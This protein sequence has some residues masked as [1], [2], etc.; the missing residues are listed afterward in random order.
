MR[1]PASTFCAL[2]ASIVL[3]ACVSSPKAED[4]LAVG[5]HSPEQTFR[6]FQTAL[7]GDQP[8]LEYACFSD[9]FRARNR[10]SRI[11]WLEARDELH[12]E[13]PFIK[14]LGDAEILETTGSESRASIVA[15]AKF[16]FCERT[17]IVHFV[18]EDFWEVWSGD[19]LLSDDYAELDEIVRLEDG[20]ILVRIDGVDGIEITDITRVVADRYW[21]IDDFAE[22]TDTPEP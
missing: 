21:K 16:L 6:T 3:S 19:D 22:V 4:W 17:F 8:F 12:R 15:R 18:R 9:S 20:S 1:R 10:L 14:K 2:L 5:Y 11:V 13:I 7:K